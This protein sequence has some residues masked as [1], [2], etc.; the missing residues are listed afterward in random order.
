MLAGEQT[1]DE[2]V[3]NP[4]SWYEE[5]G[6]TLHLGKKV[7]DVDRKRRIVTA[8]DG[9]EAHYDRLLLA[10]GSNPFILPVPG[11]GSRRRDRVPRH[12][13]HQHDDRGGSASTGTRS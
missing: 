12:R 8:D 11:Q 1:L 9:T 5:N 3:L 10:T 7:V 6:I 2:I 13:R 4:M